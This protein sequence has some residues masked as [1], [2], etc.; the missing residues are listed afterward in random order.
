LNEPLLEVVQVAKHFGGV[1]AVSNATLDVQR[2]SITSLIGPNGAGK[3]TLFNLIAGVYR[4]ESG[5]VVFAGRTISG[6]RP[7][8]VA[9]AGLVRTFQHARAL[10]RMSVIDNMLLAGAGQ[11][12]EN[13][14]RVVATPRGW[15]RREREIKAQAEEL[16]KLVRLDHLARDYAGTLSGGQ[17]KLL[18]FARAL[19]S[20]PQM[21]ML[22]EPM[23]GV[24]PT[25]GRELLEHMHH[26]R[27]SRGLTF[28]LIEH[29]LEVVMEVSDRIHVM[30]EGTVIASGT[31]E[32]I[33]TDPRVIDA[34]LGAHATV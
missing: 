13:A 14:A 5:T 8:E 9:R 11:P 30:S 4:P 21:M 17:R 6:K 31:G 29:D 2:E 33:R 22:D 27:A 24:N 12:G 1:T 18:E 34:Y 3:T 10:T 23:A 15:R 19:M 20:Q 25:L 32:Q 16:L 26:L 28:L 7:H